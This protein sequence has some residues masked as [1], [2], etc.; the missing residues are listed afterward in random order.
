MLNK[1]TRLNAQKCPTKTDECRLSRAADLLA[2]A[3]SNARRFVASGR[4]QKSASGLSAEKCSGSAAGEN[5]SARLFPF[6]VS[7]NIFFPR[8]LFENVPRDFRLFQFAPNDAPKKRGGA[9]KM[10]SAA[11]RLRAAQTPR[12]IN[13]F[14]PIFETCEWQLDIYPNFV[15]FFERIQP[16]L[17]SFLDFYN[18]RNLRIKR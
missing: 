14:P 5:A 12:S 10:R 1:I 15:I 3:N 13:S 7:G 2:R 11:R 16:F 9:A 18:G 8:R 17:P 4:R 6:S